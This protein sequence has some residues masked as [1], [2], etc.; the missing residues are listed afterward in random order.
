MRDERGGISLVS[1]EHLTPGM[2]PS[3]PGTGRVVVNVVYD[4]VLRG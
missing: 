2:E 3:A 4:E 1:G